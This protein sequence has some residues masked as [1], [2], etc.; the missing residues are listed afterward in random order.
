MA[1]L[2]MNFFSPTLYTNTDLKVILP[3]PNSYEYDEPGGMDYFRPGVKYQ[4]LYLL[5]G[6]AGDYTHWTRYSSIERYAQDRRLLVVMPSAGNSFY[7]DMAQGGA[8]LTYLT[9]ELPRF[10]QA[11]FPVTGKREDTFIAGL[12][13]GGYGAVKCAFHAPEQYG[14]C[15]SLSGALDVPSLLTKLDANPGQAKLWQAV[16]GDVPAAAEGEGNLYVLA[17]KR[18]A[19]GRKLPPVFQTIGTEDYLYENNRLA[20][21]KFTRMGLDLTYTEHPGIHFWTFWDQY[22]QE[23]LDWMPL[24]RDVL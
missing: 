8:Y 24:K 16:F 7:Q 18:L 23:A 13:M 6:L 20:R 21:E 15:A 22:I 17:Q 11:I 3:T 14:A 5:H 9:Q 1:E 2:H 12:S 10:I 4:V 19:E